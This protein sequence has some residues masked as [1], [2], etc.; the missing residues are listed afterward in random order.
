LYVFLLNREWAK[1]FEAIGA[2][3]FPTPEDDNYVYRADQVGKLRG[4]RLKAHRE[5]VRHFSRAFGELEDREL[6]AGR[7]KDA[8]DVIRRWTRY[9]ISQLVKRPVKSLGFYRG[10]RDD[11]STAIHS[12]RNFAN[13]SL[14]GR[15]FYSN[16]EPVGYISGLHLTEDTFLVLNQKNDRL[17]GLS[18]TVF[19]RFAESLMD[20]YTYLNDGADAGIAS[21]RFQ[22]EH[23]GPC[24]ILNTYGAFLSRE[25]LFSR[26]AE[27][28]N[29]SST[30]PN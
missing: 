27:G 15:V 14:N 25:M 10:L 17:R 21:L 28:R 26:R 1:S 30:A 29:E 20:R 13:I 22:K 3:V 12:L 24:R 19:H 8:E 4:K 7:A 9:K 16:G 18:E 11:H 5:N 23:W 6:D 2:R